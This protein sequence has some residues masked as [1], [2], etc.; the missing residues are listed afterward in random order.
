MPLM[1][2]LGGDMQWQDNESLRYTRGQPG[3]DRADPRPEVQAHGRRG[4][5]A[6][7]PRTGHWLK[8]TPAWRLDWVG[9]NFRNRLNGTTAPI[10]DYGTISQPKLSVA[11]TPAQRRDALWQLWQELPDRPRLGR[12]SD[13]A[14]HGQS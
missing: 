9:G 6:A 4:L 13:P 10:N 1:A 3:A 2:E 5:C 12:L 7:D 11:M 8:I 14:A